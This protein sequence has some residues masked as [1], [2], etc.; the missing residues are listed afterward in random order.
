LYIADFCPFIDLLWTKI[1]DLL[2]L[3]LGAIN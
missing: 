3:T 2:V 1:L